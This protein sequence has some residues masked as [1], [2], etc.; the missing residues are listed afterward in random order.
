MLAGITPAYAGKTFCASVRKFNDRDHPR[1][2]G[3]DFRSWGRAATSIGSPPLTR[4][5]PPK[6]ITATPSPRITPA[7]A[8]KTVKNLLLCMN[9][10]DHPRLRGKDRQLTK[11]QFKAL[12]SP[13]LTRERHSYGDS[14]LKVAGITPAYAGKTIQT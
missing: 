13:P 9:G 14:N 11:D 8:G 6:A 5:R 10:R 12:G 2:R 7:Y 4:E 3:K 1:L